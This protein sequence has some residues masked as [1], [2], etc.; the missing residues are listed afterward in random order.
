M[1]S[2]LTLD[3]D[4]RRVLAAWAAACAARA[5]PWFE[6]VAPGDA[7]PRH[8][9]AGARAFAR[10]RLRVGVA[11]GLAVRAHAAARDVTDAAA[12]AAARAAGHA[13]ATA[14]MG[15]HAVG[16]PAYA[17]HAAALARPGDRDAAAR[18]CRWAVAHASPAVRTALRRLP[19][20]PASA[21]DLGRLVHDLHV[22]LTAP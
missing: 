15:A 8:A 5:L 1:A 22:A 12:C 9:I 21:G 19:P 10:D 3:D 13:V 11:R 18:L 4:D 2:A 7:R 14:H 16:A 17:A 6:A 20:R